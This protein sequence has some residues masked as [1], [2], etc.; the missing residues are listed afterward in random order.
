MSAANTV[1]P[2]DFAK[3]ETNRSAE[4]ANH[5]APTQDAGQASIEAPVSSAPSGLI[6]IPQDI[7]AIAMRIASGDIQTVEITQ[8]MVGKTLGIDGHLYMI[9]GSLPQTA[10]PNAP[11]QPERPKLPAHEVGSSPK[12][13]RDLVKDV[14]LQFRGEHLKPRQIAELIDCPPSRTLKS[15]ESYVRTT[16]NTLVRDETVKVNRVKKGSRVMSVSFYIP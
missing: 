12:D 2:V 6:E 8:D 3:N 15:H 16:L 1:Q 7:L 14:L 4:N 5:V 11:I 13:L 9:G 10:K